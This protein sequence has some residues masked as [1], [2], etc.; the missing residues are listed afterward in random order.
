M[1]DQ[2]KYEPLEAAAMFRDGQSARPLVEGTVARGHLDDDELFTTGKIGG[3]LS[4]EFPY[5]VTREMVDRGQERYDVF[6]APCHDRA[7]TGVGMVV[8]RGYRQ[9]PSLHDQRLKDASVGYLFDVMTN[10][11]GAMPDY[12]A[13]VPVVDRWA[14]AA[15]V[16]ALQQLGPAPA[17]AQAPSAPQPAQERH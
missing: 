17:G 12:R 5:A 6:C 1:H 9:P 7:G 14:I 15:Y 4:A 2:P 11:F 10:G 3:A 16:R 13:Q 8:R